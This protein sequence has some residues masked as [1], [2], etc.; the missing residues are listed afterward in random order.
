MPSRNGFEVLD[1]IRRHP[2]LKVLR[3]IVLTN[4]GNIGDVTKA[5]RLGAN[6]FI[7][8]PAHSKRPSCRCATASYKDFKNST[9]SS[10]CASLS[11]NEKCVL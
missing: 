6:S 9:R 10:F 7:V 2:Q 8:K 11:F 4:S 5:Y 1:W 3:V